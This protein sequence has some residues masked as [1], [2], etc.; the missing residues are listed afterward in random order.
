M[1]S[2]TPFYLLISILIIA[3]LG[4]SIYRHEV[5]GVPWT[6]G[7]K[8]TAWELES[9]IEFDAIEQPV[10]VSMAAPQTQAGFTQTS[11]TT[12][13]PGYGVTTLET[14]TGPRIE[15]SIRQATGKQVLYYKTQMLVDDQAEQA[16]RVPTTFDTSITLTGPQ[17]TAAV[18]LLAQAH[19]QSADNQTLT[20]ELIKALN[21]KSNQ[22]ASLLLHSITREQAIIHILALEKIHARIVDTLSLEDGRRRQ[23]PIPMVEIWGGK[24]WQL[25]NPVSG[26]E[27]RSTHTLIWSTQNNRLLDVEGGQNSA[28]SFSILAQDLTPQQATDHKIKMEDLLNFSIHSLPIEEQ[29]MFKTIML[30]PIGALIVV[31]LRIIVGLKTSGTFMPILIAVSFVQTQLLT[32]IIGFLLVVGTGLIIR[33]YLSKLNLLLVSRISAVIISVILI[34]SIFTIAA[35]KIGLL[36]GLSITFF[37]M[38]I[39]SWT[40]ER[41]SIIW[42]EDGWKEVLVQGG[43]SLFTAVLVYLAMTNEL[44]RHLTFNFMGLQLVILAIILILGNYTGY[45]LSELRRFKPLVED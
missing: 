6:Q 18:E 8:H 1:T 27:G 44:I 2:R 7:E 20:R 19:H 30:I 23:N 12:S 42:E 28:I 11:E 45:R 41:M 39:L 36:E 24:A 9:R 15:W 17:Q 26:L 10:K 38:I 29:A 43:G 14:P 34:I 35:F 40:I 16:Q 3:G 32:G 21:D 4:L 5:Y 13:S 33:S 31:F 37:P 22:N 25:F